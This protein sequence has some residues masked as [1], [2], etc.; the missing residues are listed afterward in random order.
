MGTA[1]E[2]G[3]D[4]ARDAHTSPQILE[5]QLTPSPAP[6]RFRAEAKGQRLAEPEKG[7]SVAMAQLGRWHQALS[8]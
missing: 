6:L 5:K 4:C 3:M 1:Q 7:R 2:K 8:A